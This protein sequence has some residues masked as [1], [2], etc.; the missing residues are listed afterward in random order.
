MRAGGRNA[1]DSYDVSIHW[2]WG[3][4]MCIGLSLLLG[5]GAMLH[6]QWRFKQTALRTQGEI[7]SVELQRYRNKEGEREIYC[8]TVAYRIANLDYS[9]SA[10]GCSNPAA[11]EIGDPVPVLYQ[12]DN[13]ADARVDSFLSLGLI[14]LLLALFG[15]FF[16]LIGILVIAWHLKEKFRVTGRR[17]KR[18]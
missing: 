4:P 6:S 3:L 15:S 16:T 1:E 12:P 13:P 10:G 7:S 9:V 5:L 11:Y 2:L 14:P 17:R 18:R 8:A